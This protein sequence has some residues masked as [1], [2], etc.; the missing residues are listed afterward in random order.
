METKIIIATDM[1]CGYIYDR[2][3]RKSTKE[4]G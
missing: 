4:G 2:E 3:G 1:I